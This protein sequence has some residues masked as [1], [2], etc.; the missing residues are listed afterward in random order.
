MNPNENN[1]LRTKTS[2]NVQAIFVSYN[3]LH[4]LDK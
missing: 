2:E 3:N 1:V 4:D